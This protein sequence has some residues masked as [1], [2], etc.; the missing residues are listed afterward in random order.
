MRTFR[1]TN[2]AS[3][4]PSRVQHGAGKKRKNKEK[5]KKEK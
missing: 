2:C 3:P 5:K 1:E 4:V